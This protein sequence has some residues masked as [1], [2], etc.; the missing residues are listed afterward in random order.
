MPLVLIIAFEYFDHKFLPSSLGDIYNVYKW[1]NHLKYDIQIFTDIINPENNNYDSLKSFYHSLNNK[2]ITYIHTKSSFIYEL[3]NIFLKTQS[4][5]LFIYYTGHGIQHENISHLL[6]PDLSLISHSDFKNIIVKYTNI[7]T[8]IVVVMDCCN[9][10]NFSLPIK[11]DPTLFKM[12]LC[13]TNFL[14]TKHKLLMMTS[15]IMGQE[16]I[17]TDKGSAFTRYFFRFLITLSFSNSDYH[18]KTIYN[19]ISRILSK[20][21]LKHNTNISSEQNFYIYSSY[22]ILPVIPLWLFESV[23]S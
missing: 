4:D 6:L 21:H 5:K 1:A 22:F 17:S 15:T 2:N 11:Y 20:T 16:S 7:N 3:T 12:T 9:A 10:S 14:S 8:N 18:F 23:S 13:S 19:T